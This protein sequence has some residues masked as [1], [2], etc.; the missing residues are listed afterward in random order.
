MSRIIALQEQ[1]LALSKN[2]LSCSHYLKCDEPAKSFAFV[3]RQYRSTRES[4]SQLTSLL[5]DASSM[6][7]SIAE[8]SVLREV[9]D[10][11]SDEAKSSRRIRSQ[12]ISALS[13]Q[14]IVS[15]D[16]KF[17]ERDFPEAPN[18]V[19]W[20]ESKE[21]L[22]QA[23]FAAQAVIFTNIFGE[24]CVAEGSQVIT[25]HGLCRVEELAG[26]H[27]G[28]VPYKTRLATSVGVE[29]T[30]HAGLTSKRR[31]CLRIS[32]YKEGRSIEVTPEHR[33]LVLR[34]AELVWLRASELRVGDYMTAKLGQDLWPKASVRLPNVTLGDISGPKSVDVSFTRVPKKSNESLA[35]LAGYLLSDGSVGRYSMSFINTSKALADDFA[36]CVDELF[37]VSLNFRK[38]VPDS[39]NKACYTTKHNSVTFMRM[40]EVIGIGAGNFNTKTVPE[41]VRKGPK[42]EVI[43]FLR[44][45]FDCDGYV[46]KKRVGIRMANKSIIDDVSLFLDNLGIYHYREVRN[47]NSACNRFIK[48]KENRGTKDLSYVIEI[49]DVQKFCSVIGSKHCG[50]QDVLRHNL[51][52]AENSADRGSRKSYN[53]KPGAIPNFDLFVQRLRGAKTEY[54][55][56]SLSSALNGTLR[57]ASVVLNRVLTEDLR[58]YCARYGCLDVYETLQ[59]LQAKDFAYYEIC[60]ISEGGQHRVYDLTVPG[61]ESFMCNGVVVHN[62]PDH[63]DAEYMAGNYNVDDT[64]SD[65]R[66]RVTLLEHGKCPICHKTRTDLINE[67]KLN[68]YN[69]GAVCAGQRSG[70]SAGLAM[71]FSYLTHRTLKMEK[72]IQIYGVMRGQMLHGTYVALTYAQAKDTLYDPY[73]AALLDSPWFANYISAL[74]D[75][76][77]RYGEELYKLKDTFTLFRHRGLYTYPAGPDKRVLRGRTRIFGAIDELGWFPHDVASSKNVKMNAKEV[78]IAIERSLLT[79]RASASD[80][81]R[82]GFNNIPTGYFINISSPSSVRDMIMELVRKSQGSRRLYGIVRA[83]WEMNPKVP[84]EE[85]D[86]EFRK[87]PVAA[88]RDYGAQ[89]PLSSNPFI[90]S[91]AKVE[92]AAST[93]RVNP[94]RI[95]YKTFTARDNTKERY[96]QFLNLKP[97]KGKYVLALDAGYSNN[98]FAATLTHL[99]EST[100]MIECPLMVEIQPLPGLPLNIGLVYKHI[101]S[102]IMEKFDV[103][104]IAADRWQ[105]LKILSDAEVDFEVV[106]VQHS[107]KYAE[108]HSFKQ[109]LM[110]DQYTYPKLS[111]DI[112][113]ILAYEHSEYPGCFKDT[114]ADHFA[115]QCLT[116]Q[117]T[118]LQVIKGDNLTDDLLRSAMLGLAVLMNPKYAEHF[119]DPEEEVDTVR[120]NQPVQNRVFL[121][122]LAGVGTRPAGQVASGGGSKVRGFIARRKV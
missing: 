4:I 15:P 69:E 56:A 31:K 5:N 22:D 71:A 65:F 61:S 32:T 102:P 106:K 28:M 3:C 45:L 99:N 59:I 92:D 88:M 50:R 8:S 75:T 80:L 103:R 9:L 105:S 20:C 27:V 70:K 54:H 83:T 72:P 100:G 30:S 77:A 14:R 115:L 26:D 118:G 38:Y 112:D 104:I 53:V 60:E 93:K 62:C 90:G 11:D 113:E 66:S 6:V 21:F 36:R 47:S 18:F 109:Y 116:V 94:C 58:S 23:P 24:W 68:F 51:G 85:I 1:G 19:T 52:H 17:P 2:C 74:D 110:D 122:K 81:L 120:S 48:N 44:A 41:F 42:Q 57:N 111:K 96:A 29:R 63:S 98:S 16:V 64:M 37:G 86:E 46:Q 49:R 117:D 82:R 13:E 97:V 10:P 108:M 39:G 79:V 12:I 101:L 121:K 89:P 40:L 25:E 78:Y 91:K 35:A 33:M 67:R 55:G 43:A 84:R 73:Y 87:D 95:T 107:L 7:P 34:G 119:E 76:G 114:P